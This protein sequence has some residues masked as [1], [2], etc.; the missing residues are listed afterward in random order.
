M[1]DEVRGLIE[2]ETQIDGARGQLERAETR[3]RAAADTCS[4]PI[5]ESLRA[6]LDDVVAVAKCMARLQETV[7][8]QIGAVAPSIPCGRCRTKMLA[9]ARRCLRCSEPVARV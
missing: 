9:S 5:A 8:D 6:A 7:S 2:L 3:L 1:K 4:E